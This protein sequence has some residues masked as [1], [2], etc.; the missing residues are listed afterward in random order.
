MEGKT[1]IGILMYVSFHIPVNKRNLMH[2]DSG[3]QTW[4]ASHACRQFL[5]LS[6][7]PLHT[8]VNNL[9]EGDYVVS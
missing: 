6:Y 7:F 8:Y 3:S 5:H 4:N 9:E 2:G 1:K